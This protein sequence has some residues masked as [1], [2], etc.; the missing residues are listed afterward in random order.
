[1]NCSKQFVLKRFEPTHVA[2][3]NSKF[4][5]G[6]ATVDY[7]LIHLPHE[8]FLPSKLAGY[9]LDYDN[10]SKTLVKSP[11]MYRAIFPERLMS[12]DTMHLI[13]VDQQ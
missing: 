8:E 13:Q 12:F 10:V 9:I 5:A 6:E 11:L 7:W 3:Q 4:G 2:R 1:M